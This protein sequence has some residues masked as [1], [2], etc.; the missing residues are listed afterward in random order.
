M[1]RKEFPRATPESVGIKS[2]W[3][4]E[5]IKKLE[6]RGTRPAGFMVYRHGKVVAETWWKPFSSEIPH[7][8]HSLGK[9]F[10]AALVG[11]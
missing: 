3:I 9:S 4:T 10:T 11:I 5:C 8:N 6:A 2:E 7:S 1:N